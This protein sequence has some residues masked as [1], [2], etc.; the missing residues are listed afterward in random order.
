MSNRPACSAG[1]MPSKPVLVNFTAT[2]SSLPSAAPR[3]GSRPMMVLLSLAKDSTG[4]Y[5]A[6]VAMVMTPADLIL[7]GSAI[8][9]PLDGAAEAADVVA[10][11]DGADEVA[12]AGA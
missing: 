7:A 1:M 6:S 5:D 3:S 10:V 9:A 8:P 2:P 4:A 11:A 12:D